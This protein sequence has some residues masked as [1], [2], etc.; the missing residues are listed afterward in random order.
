MMDFGLSDELALLQATARA[1]V[2]RT[3]PP[4]RAKEWDEK[5]EA[6]VEFF[7]AMAELGWFGLA[8]PE[9]VGGGGGWH[10]AFPFTSTFRSTSVH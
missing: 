5:G 1:F 10:A 6:P 3:C 2:D 9:D 8:F 4:E 7:R